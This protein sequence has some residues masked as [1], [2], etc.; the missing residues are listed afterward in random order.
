MVRPG[1]KARRVEHS[2]FPAYVV[3]AYAVWN[4][5]LQSKMG[6]WLYFFMDYNRPFLHSCMFDGLS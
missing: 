2:I 4:W 1:C 6:H 5:W 3:L